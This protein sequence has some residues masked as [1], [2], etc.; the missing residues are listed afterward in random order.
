KR[1]V[2]T[3][4]KYVVAFVE[5]RRK[6]NINR[7]TR[8]IGDKDILDR[9][10]ALARSLPTHRLAGRFYDVRRG[11]E[12]VDIG[13]TH[14]QKQDLVSLLY[15]AVGHNREISDRVSQVIEALRRR[16]FVDLS[17]HEQF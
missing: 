10:H 7:F 5:Q 15:D 8:A 9:G 1:V 14:V 12:I 11:N 17:W 2:R 16:N 4:C 13:I 6:T 3:G